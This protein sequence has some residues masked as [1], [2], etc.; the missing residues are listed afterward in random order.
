MSRSRL[1]K[2]GLNIDHVATVRQARGGNQPDVMSV[3]W[4]GIRGGADGITVHLRE[5]RRHIQ[6]QDVFELKRTISVPLNLEM[7]VNE[8]IVRVAMKLKPEKAC[9]VPERREELT[10]EGGLDVCRG[11]KRIQQVVCLLQARGISVSLFI[12]PVPGQVEAAGAMG[13]DFIELHTGCYANRKG[14]RRRQELLRLE[15]AARL[16]HAIGLGVNAGHG[17]DYENV[18]PIAKLPF[19][20]E[21]NIGHAIIARAIFVGLRNAVR[22]MR[23][24]ISS[25]SL[26]TI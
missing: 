14:A 9:L 16:A 11:R 3:A 15:K 7:S 26:R 22:E 25:T 21:L 23:Q 10:T 18:V 20:D 12:D 13:C 2:L 24:L 5:D 17:L 6:D 1:V 4:E 19:I 8:D